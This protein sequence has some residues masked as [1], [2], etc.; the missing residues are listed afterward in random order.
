M[1]AGRRKELKWVCQDREH[2]G[3]QRPKYN[4]EHDAFTGLPGVPFYWKVG[5]KGGRGRDELRHRHCPDIQRP[6]ICTHGFDFIVKTM[7]FTD[8]FKQSSSDWFKQKRHHQKKVEKHNWAE[9]ET[10]KPEWKK[11]DESGVEG[12]EEIAEVSHHQSVG[13]AG[14][15]P[16]GARCCH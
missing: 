12:A 6:G 11:E 7:G 9:R 16:L 1:Y 14:P 15:I 8:V 5:C 4:S 10:R 3:S 2:V 13:T